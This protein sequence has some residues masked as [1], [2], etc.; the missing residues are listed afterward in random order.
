MTSFEAWVKEVQ[1]AVESVARLYDADIFLFAGELLD[2]VGHEFIDLCPQTPE[3][4]N[5][6][7]LLTTY[8]GSTETAYRIA[9]CIQNRYTADDRGQFILFAD[10]LCK[11]AGTLVALGADTLLM[12]DHAE[13]GPLDTQVVSPDK[14]AELQ[15]G[16][17]DTDSLATLRQESF[18]SF[19]EH[20]R[21]LEL[22]GSDYLTTHTAAQLATDLTVGM[23]KE[24]YRQ[25][26]PMRLGESHRAV[27]AVREY[28]HRVQTSNVSPNTIPFLTD[29]YPS[30]GFLIDRREATEL[31]Y[32]VHPPDEQLSMLARLMKPI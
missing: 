6:I 23:F 9:R 15:S 30:H 12:S 22:L 7:L 25:I 3:V 27:Q 14:F 13:L 20:F 10:G 29:K 28:G 18:A 17:V 2:G 21:R 19:E 16:L 32:E 31:F 4:K 8:G 5:C 11:S 24:V 1:A 26:N